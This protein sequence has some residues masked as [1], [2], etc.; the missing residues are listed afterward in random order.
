MTDNWSR[1]D[2]STA[3]DRRDSADCKIVC[4]IRE[5]RKG[6]MNAARLVKKYVDVWAP[7]GMA[8]GKAK[9]AKN[10]T[11]PILSLR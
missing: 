8:S 3:R 10:T 7:M 6:M 2:D 11:R 5:K 4:I 1:E 9:A